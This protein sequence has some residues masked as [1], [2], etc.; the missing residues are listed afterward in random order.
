[1]RKEINMETNSKKKTTILIVL[2]LLVTT[3]AVGVTIWALF[4]REPDTILP[5]DYAPVQTDPN[6]T[7]I[8]G[9]SGDKMDVE[10]GGG[11]V[12]LTY[13]N[14]VT[15]DLSDGKATLMFANPGKSVQD[16]VVQIIVQDTVLVQSG[17]L[18]PGNQVTTLDLLSGAAKKLAPGG[19]DGKF[20]ISYYDP[21]SG[22]M[23][24]VN[25]EIPI[26]VTVQE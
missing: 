8:D 20:L 19:Y 5:P 1:M 17:R 11:A 22:E 26:T 15:I 18:T 3:I 10:E 21:E 14:K 13:S 12:S 23:A 9:D 2:L 4:F 24:V 6:Q 7:P 25:T 16:M